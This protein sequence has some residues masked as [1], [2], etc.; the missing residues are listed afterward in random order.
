MKVLF[1]TLLLCF[2]L[3]ASTDISQGQNSFADQ[4]SEVTPALTGTM[5]PNASVKTVDGKSVELRTLVSEK[6]TVLIFYRGGWCPY[7]NKHLEELQQI[8]QQLVDMG[9]QILAVSPDRPEILKESISKHNLDYTLL[10][11]S[12]MNLTKALG[13]AFMVDDKTVEQ[14][15][16]SGIDL[17]K[18]S[19]YDHH[20]LPVPAVYLINPDGRITFQYV[21]PNYKT[22]IDSDVLMSAAKAYHPDAE[23]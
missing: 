12:P 23:Q 6:P 11:D 8:E 2:I 10:S 20:L 18:N 17:E 16:Q 14:Y 5:V 3:F 21:N 19:G 13:L 4:A 1:G 7:C 15:K 22:R 9:Y